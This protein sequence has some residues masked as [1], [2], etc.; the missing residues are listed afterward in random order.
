[1]KISKAVSFIISVVCAD[2]CYY[3]FVFNPKGD[4]VRE[5]CAQFL[6]MT[7]E[8]LW[9]TFELIDDKFILKWKFIEKVSIY[10][11]V[12]LKHIIMY[13]FARKWRIMYM[14]NVIKN[15]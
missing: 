4:C 12:N 5:T 7:D 1:M 14:I 8:T 15:E 2:G 10:F 13:V 11:F 3:K 6:E 9:D